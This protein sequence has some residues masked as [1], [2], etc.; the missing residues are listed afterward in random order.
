MKKTEDR[1]IYSIGILFLLLGIAA[2]INTIYRGNFQGILWLCYIGIV[3]IGFG[4]LKKDSLL[5]TSQ[6]NIL[7]IP[8]IIWTIDFLHFILTGNELLGIVNYFFD[9]SFPLISKIISMQ[10]LFTIPLSIYALHKLKP[11]KINAW[12]FS[13][14]QLVFI[15]IITKILTQPENNINCVYE[16][17][18]NITLN[19]ISYPIVWFISVFLLVLI[20]NRLISKILEIINH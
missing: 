6:L 12:K 15:F 11:K 8:L 20:T 3:I 13:F 5:I 9:P 19:T 17:C 1:I 10:H 4:I 18:M 14:I 7:F 2:V 16:S